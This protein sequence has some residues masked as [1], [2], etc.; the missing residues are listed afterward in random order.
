MKRQVVNKNHSFQQE[1]KGSFRGSGGLAIVGSNNRATDMT[2]VSS[3]SAIGNRLEFVSG[4]SLNSREEPRQDPESHR[5][6]AEGAA[7]PSREE[8]EE[9]G[10]TICH[11]VALAETNKMNEQNL[12][13]G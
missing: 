11:T 13:D 5:P 10:A 7:D 8:W 4:R 12:E 2:T 6:Q 3:P 9:W 1:K